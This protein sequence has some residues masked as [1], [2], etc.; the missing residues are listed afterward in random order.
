M[1]AVPRSVYETMPKRMPL[2]LGFSRYSLDFPGDNYVEVPD[3]PEL[4]A[5][6]PFTVSAWIY[7]RDLTVDHTIIAKWG[8]T[9]REWTFQAES[10]YNRLRLAVYDEVA[11][12]STLIDL[13]NVLVADKWM[14]VVAVYDGA[15][16]YARIHRDDLVNEYQAI[17]PQTIQDTAQDVQVGYRADDAWGPLDGLVVNPMIYSAKLTAREVVHNM[18]NYHNPVR[19]GLVMWLPMEEGT[20]LTAHDESG[21]GNDGS[22]LP[23]ADPPLWTRNEKW[24][25]R[26]EAGL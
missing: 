5:L 6:D 18:L 25:L 23:A 14:Y 8:G 3:A 15:N 16:T 11:D 21:E 19:D 9:T 2:S 20:G 13:N 17:T 24:E 12:T 4:S 26:A 22:L 1:V 10:T 7:L